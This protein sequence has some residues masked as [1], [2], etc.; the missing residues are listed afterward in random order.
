MYSFL[1]LSPIKKT[2]QR[3]DPTPLFYGPWYLYKIKL[4]FTSQKA[5]KKLPFTQDVSTGS[6]ATANWET[7]WKCIPSIEKSKIASKT[8]TADFTVP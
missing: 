5:D 7:L 1:S 4:L 2:I 8:S 3:N 6:D